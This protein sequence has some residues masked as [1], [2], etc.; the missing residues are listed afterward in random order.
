MRYALMGL[1]LAGCVNSYGIQRTGPDRFETSALA[2]PLAGGAG[3]AR[4]RAL[5]DATKH[6]ESMGK[7]VEV[8]DTTNRYSFPAN[9]VATVQF[10]C[11]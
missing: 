10:A 9:S 4:A 1:V 7:Q 2:A 8:T 3:G 5:E 6:C 11:R